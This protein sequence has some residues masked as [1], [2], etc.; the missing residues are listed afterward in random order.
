M[1][2]IKRML[3]VAKKE[4]IEMFRDPIRVCANFAVPIVLMFLFSSGM[5]MDIRNIPFV[6]LDLD[7]T[8]LSR[9]YADAYIN[10]Y[11]FLYKGNV[12]SEDEA[13]LRLQ[14]GKANFYLE[15]PSGFGRSVNAGKSAQVA[16]F[17]DGTMPTRANN[18]RGYVSGVNAK[19]LANKAVEELGQ[20]NIRPTYEIKS[21]YWYNQASASKYTFVPGA[22]VIILIS[23]PAVMMTL[24]IVKEKENGTITNFY[25]TP[26]TK[27]EF[28]VG[29][30][31]IYL[32]IFM[33]S[34]FILVGIATFIYGVPIKGSF[35]LMTG[36]A[37]MYILCTTSLGLLI[38]SFVKSQIA[39]LL[40]ALITTMMPAFNYSGL[41]TPIS[42]LEPSAQFTARL[43]PVLFFMRTVL[44][45]F[46]KDTPIKTL[47][48]NFL[49]LAIFYLIITI[50][51]TVL[52]KKQEK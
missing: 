17:I 33:I 15:I 47:L 24:S 40:I 5:N 29:K 21:R 23:V 43:Y 38:S 36:M 51:C 48:P 11:Y 35:I 14:Q 28:L 18:V 31:L 1:F 13:E 26:L 46:T 9:E 37:F 41:L 50:A 16:T 19:Y 52:L 34:Y 39:G 45:T 32:L 42:S 30:Q 2:S 12:F 10:S 3:T 8:K 6:I 44:G 25:A 49:Y 4:T 7:N 22:I 27:L 20:V